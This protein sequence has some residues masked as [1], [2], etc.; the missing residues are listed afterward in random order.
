MESAPSGV[1]C[2][3]TASS[4]FM[5][6]GLRAVWGKSASGAWPAVG[7]GE[8]LIPHPLQAPCMLLAPPSP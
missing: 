1:R 8:S 4:V 2:A 3:S 7:M 6:S 5:S